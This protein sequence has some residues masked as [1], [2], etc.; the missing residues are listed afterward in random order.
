MRPAIAKEQDKKHE[1]IKL[2]VWQVCKAEFV[3]ILSLQICNM[4]IDTFS[5]SVYSLFVHL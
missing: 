3:K 2:P 5:R 1:S 4:N